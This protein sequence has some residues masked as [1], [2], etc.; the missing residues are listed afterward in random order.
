ML[1]KAPIAYRLTNDSA[2]IWWETDKAD[3]IYDG[4]Y[5]TL[6]GEEEYF[7]KA[8][9]TASVVNTA[10]ETAYV[11]HTYL[12]NLTPDSLLHVKVSGKD[13]LTPVAT[14]F[15]TYADNLPVTFGVINNPSGFL[16][17]DLPSLGYSI[18]KLA[19]VDCYISC[20]NVTKAWGAANYEDYE[21][22]YSVM[23]SVS[24]SGIIAAR[25]DTDVGNFSNAMYP[26]T[27]QG[28]AYY[29]ASVGPVRFMVLD[30]TQ[31][32]RISMRDGKQSSWAM[33]E[34]GS[35]E[36]KNAKY[37][38]ILMGSPFRTSY[39]NEGQMFAGRS[40]GTDLLLENLIYPILKRSGADIIIAGGQSYQR[41]SMSS[42]YPNN[43]GG[44][45]HHVVC[46]G[47]APAHLD[48]R[49]S[50]DP[51]KDPGIVVETSDYHYVSISAST[52]GMTLSC[53][54]AETDELID[55]IAVS[56]HTLF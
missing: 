49:W 24:G 37:R 43:Q 4:L 44:V 32:G 6:P 39:W 3:P 26:T 20:G 42:T 41:G 9:A 55:Y 34:I 18:G 45:T 47:S 54:N 28:K 11:H 13:L 19:T 52:T 10:G 21:S 53:L 16:G 25:G 29:S 33:N 48:K 12:P 36:W 30:V 46:G 40:T 31:V 14:T 1:T 22:W 23:S 8:T 56:P 15:R 51:P 50:W 17:T 38:I 35:N 2:I 7:K 27:V 5:V